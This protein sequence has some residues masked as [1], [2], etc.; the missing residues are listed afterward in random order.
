M[1][2]HEGLFMSQTT[3][4]IPAQSSQ[5]ANPHHL[6]DKTLMIFDWDGTLMDSIGLIVEAMHIAGEAHG[7]KT[8]DKAVKDIIGLSLMKG[9][10][11]L[12]PHSSDEQKLLIQQ[13]YADY[14]IA[15]SQRTLFFAPIEN[16]LQTLQQQ[17]VSLQLRQVKNVRV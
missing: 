2:I 9:I 6:A 16:M 4:L 14:Y 15:N 8:T 13:S 7:F 12:Y 11:L 5:S 10:E 1:I 17:I 3:T